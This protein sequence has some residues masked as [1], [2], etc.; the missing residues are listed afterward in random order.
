MTD[1]YVQMHDGA[2]A[3]TEAVNTVLNIDRDTEGGIVGFEILGGQRVDVDGLVVAADG[4]TKVIGL[5]GRSR[6][7]VV[8]ALHEVVDVF[9]GCCLDGDAFVAA[10][11]SVLTD[12][13]PLPDKPAGEPCGGVAEVPGER[14]EWNPTGD[15]WLAGRV[16]DGN[17]HNVAM[18]LDH[19]G[20]TLV[21]ERRHTRALA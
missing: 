5:L 14:L 7:V 2:V 1:V 3:A 9:G 18:Q 16:L 17:G 6:E 8:E 13:D 4:T 11:M 15:V 21:V 20:Q 19:N 10:L 12:T